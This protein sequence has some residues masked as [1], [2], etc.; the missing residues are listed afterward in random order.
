MIK[1]HSV[2]VLIIIIASFCAIPAELLARAGGGKGGGALSGIVGLLF[3]I[4]YFLVV[5]IAYFKNLHVKKILKRI[6]RKDDAWEYN[7]IQQG[8]KDC[9]YMVQ[10]AWRCRNQRLAI[11]YTTQRLYTEHK[12]QLDRMKR[13]KHVNILSDIKINKI[14]LI[15]LHDFDDNDKDGFCALIHGS[16]VDYTV[17][18]TT[19]ELIEGNKDSKKFIELW[20]F[21]RQG[22]KFVLSQIDDKVFFL[23]L[24]N[25]NSMY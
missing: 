10:E 6:A 3:L 13:R 19:R 8:I 17:H 23:N 15:E 24:I 25:L 20:H 9:F 21:Q 5:I 2:L 11:E 12:T 18:E 16:M 4:N 14:D 1:K 7:K 22:D